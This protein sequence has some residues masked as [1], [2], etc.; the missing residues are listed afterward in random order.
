MVQVKV[1]QRTVQRKTI[2]ITLST[3]VQVHCQVASRLT[4]C[5]KLKTR[6]FNRSYNA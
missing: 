4:F 6:F 5:S 2:S 3:A 1:Q